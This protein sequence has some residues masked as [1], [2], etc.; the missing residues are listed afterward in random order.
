LVFGPVPS[1]LLVA[2]LEM[3]EKRDL[4]SKYQE[5]LGTKSKEKEEKGG[6]RERYLEDFQS[7]IISTSHI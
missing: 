7:N 3:K 4:I 5:V 2:A 1:K 6:E